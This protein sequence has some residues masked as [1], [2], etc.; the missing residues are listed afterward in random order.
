MASVSTN[1]TQH[2]RVIG[3]HCLFN[4]LFTKYMQ[5]DVLIFSYLANTTT[6]NNIIKVS[7]NS[8]LLVV[9]DTR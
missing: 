8:N 5:L 1:Q 9:V 4:C 6:N 2:N 3:L 7:F